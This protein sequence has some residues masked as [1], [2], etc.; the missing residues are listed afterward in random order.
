[1]Q[2]KYRNR[3]HNG[4]ASQR[5]AETAANL[6]ALAQAGV[7]TGLEE[8]VPYRLVPAQKGKVRNEKGITYVAD[9]VYSDKDGKHVVDAKGY[10]TRDYVMKRKLMAYLLHIEVEEL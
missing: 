6:H 7:I 5:E 1:M 2:N 3:R 9:F 4:Y 8:Q 10:K